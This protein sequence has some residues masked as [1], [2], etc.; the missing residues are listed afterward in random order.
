MRNGANRLPMTKRI[1]SACSATSPATASTV[2]ATSP[3]ASTPKK[4]MPASPG[5]VMADD[6]VL[7]DLFHGCALAAFVEEARFRQGWPDVEAT[8]RRAFR[9]YEAALADK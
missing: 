6:G 1:F 2:S 9:L 5:G 4:S 3:H 8:R 7:D